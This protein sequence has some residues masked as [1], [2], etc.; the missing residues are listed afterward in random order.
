[1]KPTQ[2]QVN[3]F[4]DALRQTGVTN[5]F[6]AKPYLQKRYP[7]L[8]SNEAGDMLVTWMETFGGERH[9]HV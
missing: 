1:M 8:K 7:I 4:L 6:S 5:M 9:K 2:E 3:N